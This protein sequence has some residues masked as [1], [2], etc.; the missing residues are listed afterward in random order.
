L[1]FLCENIYDL[2]SIKHLNFILACS[3][4]DVK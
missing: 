2:Q 1:E 3:S 4:I